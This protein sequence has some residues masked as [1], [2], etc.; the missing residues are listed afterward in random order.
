MKKIEII[1]LAIILLG[2]FIVR[3][4]KFNSP[5]A[6]WHSWRQVDTSAV[7]RNFVNNG[8]DLF[9]PKFEDL[10]KGVSLIDNPKG[11]RFVEFPAYNATQ[12]L[13]YKQIKILS[14]EQWGRLI[15]IFSSLASTVFIYLICKKYLNNT[16]AIFAAFFFAFIPYNIYYS[17]VI[18]PDPSMVMATLA[19]TYFFSKWID[20][21]R[22]KIY[23]LNFILSILFISLAFLLKP[24]ALFFMLPL[25]YLSFQ[26]YGKSFFKN[27]QLWFFAI[28]T[29]IPLIFWQIWIRQYPEGIPQNLWLF[30]GTHIRFKGAFFQWIFAQRISQLI[31]GNFG[32]PFVVLGIIR[33]I[34]QKENWFFLMFLISSLTYVTVLAT[35]NVQHDYY[36]ILI[37]PT[38]AIFFGKGVDL[39]IKNMN[40]IFNKNISY[41]LI[42]TS[43]LF[44]L[45]FGWFNVRDYYDVQHLEVVTAGEAVAKL[46]P[47][48]AK[49]IAPYGGDTTFLYYTQRVGWPVF[50]RSITDF[51][52]AGAT[53]MVFVNPGKDEL[54]W[55][56]YF[57]VLGNGDNYII[58]DL[59]K[60]LSP[61]K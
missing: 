58:Y 2:A 3:L 40:T 51:L 28:L 50:D 61:V 43:V 10:S 48:N 26:K 32:L 35:G 24:Y 21:S 17:R 23:D 53:V 4:Y 45:L 9:H 41:L 36:Q 19:G 14:L 33:K 29:S 49:V 44:M 1:L 59:T 39:I 46:T 37:V 7:S 52:K 5:V 13:L 6:D 60:S 42:F 57:A 34:N 47:I 20:K 27:W 55:Q 31:L 12:A 15:T 11:Y 54:N 22:N 16:S 30:D 8:F 18:L 25:V 56:K 38:L